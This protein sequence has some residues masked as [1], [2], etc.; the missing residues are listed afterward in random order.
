[1]SAS[2]KQ[3]AP[4][5]TP[6]PYS[7]PERA[8]LAHAIAAAADA[9]ARR[10]ALERAAQ[11]ANS[12]AL[13]AIQTVEAA[14]AALGEAQG[15]TAKHAVDK[16]L[17]NAGAAPLTVREARAAVIEAQDHLEECRATRAALKAELYASAN[18][19]S[20][21]SVEDAA[22]AVLRAEMQQRA[23]ALA[24]EVAQL[25]KDLVSKGST[26]QWLSNKG[27]LP[28]ADEATIR[29]T[30]A[31]LERPAAEWAI[32][33]VR[34]ATSVWEPTGRLKWEAAFERLKTDANAALPL[35]D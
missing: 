15:N 18:R 33:T 4:E 6:T 30:V 19:W 28:N 2:A 23:I 3:R 5:V 10:V 8:A 1:M 24:A 9:G 12:D 14:E 20:A 17:G 32:G 22:K 25:Q 26:L 16:A 35:E 31:R 7:S 27:V 29:N 13:K 34:Y 21:L 11:A